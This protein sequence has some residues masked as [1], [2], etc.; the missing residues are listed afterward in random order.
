MPSF[1][2]HFKEID[3]IIYLPSHG[4]DGR[5]YAKYG[6]AFHDRKKGRSQTGRRI[7]LNEVLNRATIKNKYPHN[8]GFFL[9]SSG[10]GKSW[11][12]DY[13]R[14]KNIRSKRGFYSYLKELAL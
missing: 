10:K 9:K 6:V 2:F 11:K 4:N 3:W 7:A 8:V 13:L 1:K 12:P 14:T 5:P